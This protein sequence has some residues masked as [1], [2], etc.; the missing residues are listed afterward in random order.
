ML[1][2]LLYMFLFYIKLYKIYFILLF[3]NLFTFLN[4]HYH[5]H[6]INNL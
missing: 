4:T 6:N 2:T 5:H 3:K 1:S